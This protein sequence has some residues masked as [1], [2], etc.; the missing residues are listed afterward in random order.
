MFDIKRFN[1]EKEMQSKQLSYQEVIFMDTEKWNGQYPQR[2]KGRKQN[3][4]I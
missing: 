1:F 2:R 3:E 4:R